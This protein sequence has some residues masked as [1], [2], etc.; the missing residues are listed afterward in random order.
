MLE[1]VCR[2]ANVAEAEHKSNVS[3]FGNCGAAGG[4][5]VLSQMWNELPSSYTSVVLVGS[6][7]SWGGLQVIPAATAGA[8]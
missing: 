5:T 4:P 2:L 7:L 6:G 1:T 8:R 3:L